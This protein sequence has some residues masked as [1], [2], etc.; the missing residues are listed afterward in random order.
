MFGASD[1]RNIGFITQMSAKLTDQLPS[2]S[3]E[4]RMRGSS[5][6]WRTENPKDRGSRHSSKGWVTVSSDT[7]HIYELRHDACGRDENGGGE[8][9]WP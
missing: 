9:G 3:M 5:R 2:A 1:S 8:G 4:M 6:I 7:L